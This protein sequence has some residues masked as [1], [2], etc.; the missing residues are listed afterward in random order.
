MSKIFR[1]KYFF[2]LRKR[3]AGIQAI[4]NQQIILP[5]PVLDSCFKKDWVVDAR[6]P[7]SGVNHVVEYL[8]RYTHKVAISNH[9]IMAIDE[10]NDTVT[11]SYKDYADNGVK[12]QL[13]L[14]SMEF[15]R[16]FCL[17]ILP[18][19]FVRIRHYG[20]LS[21]T[22]KAN[23][24]PR[25]RKQIPAKK[26][27]MI[28]TTAIPFNPIVCPCCKK[29]TMVRQLNFHQRGPPTNWKELIK[30]RIQLM[31]FNWKLL[32]LQGHGRALQRV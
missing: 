19:S 21:S 25:I 24:I 8:G 7:F 26:T 3:I 23:A 30:Q 12:K 27:L 13:T 29:E 11:F 5:K 28:K 2:H 15:I 31:K 6:K 16:R 10:Q 22:S 32:Q 18:K 9:R 4:N 14:K 17:H 1:A 20:I